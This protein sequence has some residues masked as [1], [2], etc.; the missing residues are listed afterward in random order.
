MMT[1]YIA[2]EPNGDPN[3]DSVSWIPDDMKE[4]AS[5]DKG[6]PWEELEK[7]GW[8]IREFELIERKIIAP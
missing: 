6:R 3:L 1:C 4:F 8:T 2:C 7:M 5:E